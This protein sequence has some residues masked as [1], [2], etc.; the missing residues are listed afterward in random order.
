VTATG[1]IGH[2]AIRNRATIGGSLIHNDP[3][4]EYPL[5]LLCLGAEVHVTSQRGERNI[6]VSEL[7]LPWFSTTL[8]PDELLLEIRVP[9]R[10]EREGFGFQE[11]ARRPGDFALAAAAAS[12]TLDPSGNVVEATVAASAGRCAARLAEA[13]QILRGQAPTEELLTEVASAAERETE[14]VADI[15][16]E[17]DYRRHLIGVLVRR[18]LGEAL[19]NAWAP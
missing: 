11:V 14:P 10:G 4:A 3:A 6:A 13:E 19:D 18:A 8:E 2:P 16:A 15:H 5:A 17:E 9:V 1:Y 7:L 12:V